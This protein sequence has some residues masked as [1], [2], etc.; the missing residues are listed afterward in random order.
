VVGDALAVV[1]FG[2]AHL[3]IVADLSNANQK[4]FIAMMPKI[5]AKPSSRLDATARDGAA[6]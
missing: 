5:V 6:R 4:R 1:K 2:A 3:E